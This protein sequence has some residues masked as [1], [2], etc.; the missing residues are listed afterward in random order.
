MTMR[1]KARWRKT[2]EPKRRGKN[3]QRHDSFLPRATN[4][5]R[6]TLN[7]VLSRYRGRLYKI[8]LRVTRNPEDAEDAL[9]DGLLSAYIK[10]NSFEGRSQLSTWLSRI[11]LN[12][13][14]MRL[15]RSRSAIMTSI[16]Q[17]LDRS[18][19]PLASRIP[20]LRLNPEETYKREEQYQILGKA[21]RSLPP[22]Y[23]QVLVLCDF[24]G[25]TNR[26]AAEVLG[27]HVGNLKAR[28]CRA[29][30]RLRKEA[31]KG[32]RRV[33]HLRNTRPAHAATEY[34]PHW[35]LPEKSMEVAI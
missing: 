24:Q 6:E 5:N 34:R 7:E 14:L 28:L 33:G 26:E 20:D 21:L 16:D 35:E 8:A 31:N 12:A 25:M 9:Q 27:L 29:R 32:S 30:R 19:Q 15:R 13:A 4:A 22:A 10:L 2:L 23:R 17:E 18:D 3:V 11:V 1:V